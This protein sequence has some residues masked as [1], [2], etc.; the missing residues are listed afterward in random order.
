M[1][2]S[3][4]FRRCPNCG[5]GLSIKDILSV[6]LLFPVKCRSCGS[7]VIPHKRIYPF[8]SLLLLLFLFTLMLRVGV[9]AIYDIDSTLVR[10]ILF[11]GE[12]SVLTLFISYLFNCFVPLVIKTENKKN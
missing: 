1:S 12:L 7:T 9:P 5:A 2:V 8:A 4:R 3:L 6:Y 11:L 10:V